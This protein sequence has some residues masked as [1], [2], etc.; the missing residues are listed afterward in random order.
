MSID[1]SIVSFKI[2]LCATIL[3][4]DRSPSP[5]DKGQL[6]YSFTSLDGCDLIRWCWMWVEVL[7]VQVQLLNF[8][9]SLCR[10]HGAHERS[11]RCL[12]MHQQCWEAWE[13]PGP[14]Q[15]LLQGHCALPDRH[16]EARYVDCL[17]TWNIRASVID[18]V[19]E[20]TLLLKCALFASNNRRDAWCLTCQVN[21]YGVHSVLH[22]SSVQ[23]TLESLRLLTTTEPGKLLSISMAGWTRWDA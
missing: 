20:W 14:H 19:L 23:V 16:D 11:R 6:C 18:S 15:T 1:I 21:F 12:E 8:D 9:P 2:V 5:R 22:C 10:H 17:E 3:Q 13:T 7:I 4:F